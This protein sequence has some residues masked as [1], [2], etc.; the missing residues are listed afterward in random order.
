MLLTSLALFYGLLSPNF[1]AYL[2]GKKLIRKV[3]FFSD[4]PSSEFVFEN[5]LNKRAICRRFCSTKIFGMAMSGV[6]QP[7]TPPPTRVKFKK[8]ET[9]LMF[10]CAMCSYSKALRLQ[11]LYSWYNF[12]VC[13]FYCVII[14]EH[15]TKSLLSG[16]WRKATKK[17][18]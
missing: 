1:Q 8:K 2:L 14:V 12:I 10:C 16:C 11:L 18:V 5:F 17:R 13:V 6:Y 15:V 3:R 9:T 7:P 4:I